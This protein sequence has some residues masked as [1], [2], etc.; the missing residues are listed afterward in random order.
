MWDYYIPNIC[1]SLLFWLIW[2]CVMAKYM[3]L[4]HIFYVGFAFCQI[5]CFVIFVENGMA[6]LYLY[7][8]ISTPLE[9]I[10]WQPP[11]KMSLLAKFNF[12]GYNYQNE[13]HGN[14]IFGMNN[15][16]CW[17]QIC[18]WRPFLSQNTRSESDK[19]KSSLCRSTFVTTFA[20]FYDRK[21]FETVTRNVVTENYSLVTTYFS[22]LNIN[23]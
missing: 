5:E 10:Q 16:S 11:Q 15:C 8:L 14:V 13:S 17:R 19:F 7:R 12:F 22:S 9:K 21:I 4:R 2:R 18:K 1:G 6:I 3:N 20:I 23:I